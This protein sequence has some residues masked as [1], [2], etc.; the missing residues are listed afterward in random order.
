MPPVVRHTAARGIALKHKADHAISWLKLSSGFRANLLPWALPGPT[1]EPTP[2][3]L[4][5]SPHVS[6]AAV[7]SVP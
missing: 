1:S 2:Y 7:L 6:R 4:P 3:T 5:L